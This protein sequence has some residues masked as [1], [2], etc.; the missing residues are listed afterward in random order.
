MSNG[1]IKKTWYKKWWGILLVVVFMLFFATLTAF[2]F[3][4]Y[5][6]N[7]PIKNNGVDSLK[8]ISLNY[9]KLNEQTRAKIE[10]TDNYWI[11]AAKPKITIVEFG[12]FACHHTKKSFPKIRE[13]GT[14]YKNDVKIIFRDMPLQENSLKLAMAAR[15]AGEQ[16]LFWPMYDKL[17]QN[18]GVSKDNELVEMANQIG[19]DTSRFAAC[20][21]DQKY[22]KQIQKDFSDGK[23]LGV[24]GT[25]TWFVNGVKLQGDVP[26]AVWENIIKELLK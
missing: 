8:K 23:D 22:I 19:A 11:G 1:Q 6:L 21:S 15:C 24:K 26:L 25:P 10:G 12:D 9:E 7:K 14:K 2:A 4:A 16:G 18:Q 3:Y 5:H 13:M 20:L 17:F